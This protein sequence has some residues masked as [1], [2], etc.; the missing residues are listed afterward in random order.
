MLSYS[1]KKKPNSELVDLINDD[2]NSNNSSMFV[3]VIISAAITGYAR[4]YMAMFK[5]N[6]EI[7]IDY[8]DTDSIMTSTDL[9]Q[10]HKFLRRKNL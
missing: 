4:L 3:S 10:S 2:S 8:S 6:P 1:K 9:S 7:K 5:N